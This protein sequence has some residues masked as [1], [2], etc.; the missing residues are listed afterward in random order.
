MDNIT[1]AFSLMGYAIFLLSFYI[2]LT[3]RRLF[4]ALETNRQIEARITLRNDE[5]KARIRQLAK[6]KDMVCPDIDEADI[7]PK[8]PSY[9]NLVTQTSRGDVTI[10][11]LDPSEILRTATKKSGSGDLTT[12]QSRVTFKDS[13]DVDANKDL[14]LA[15]SSKLIKTI[16]EEEEKEESP[17][18]LMPPESAGTVPG[19]PRADTSV[20]SADPPSPR[21]AESAS[22]GSPPL[23]PPSESDSPGS[24]QPGSA[25]SSTV[26]RL[27]SVAPSAGSALPSSAGSAR[28][29]SSSALTEFGS[30]VASSA[31]SADLDQSQ[32]KRSAGLVEPGS[33]S[34][35][36]SAGSA[37]LSRSAIP[38][39]SAAAGS[40]RPAG[41]TLSAGSAGPG[42]PQPSTSAG[43]APPGS[44][45]PS[46]SVGAA[47]SPKP[48][49]SVGSVGSP[50]PPK[51][52]D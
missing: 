36:P 22:A 6:M 41:S 23:I 48:T 47:G 30:P 32:A 10:P 44:V 9:E 50:G 7:P 3:T 40:P 15:T 46:S 13:K 51:P 12:S 29:V 42:L 28:V 24:P 45:G 19:S 33:P 27:P 14:K 4:Q 31:A 52:A 18:Y 49:G 35:T 38:V 43:V 16:P 25:V 39:G 37:G 5:R 34:L 11:W 26:S 8:V 1:I 17:L 20:G 21:L 2:Y